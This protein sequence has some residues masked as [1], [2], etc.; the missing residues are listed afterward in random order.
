MDIENV[1]RKYRISDK[2]PELVEFGDIFIKIKR[3]GNG[4]FINSYSRNEKEPETNDFFQT[5]SSDSL[6]LIPALQTKP[7]VFKGSSLSIMPR[8]KLTFYVKI[9]M[10]V[11]VFHTNKHHDNLI[12]EIIHTRLSDTWFGEP[13]NGEAA[14]LLGSEYF[15]HIEELKIQQ[16]EAVCPVQV[17]NNSDKIL[18]LQ[19]LILR[20]E[21]MSLYKVNENVFT[22]F[23]KLEYK[24]KDVI[25]SANYGSSK[26]YHGEKLHILAKPGNDK[27]TPLKINFHFI[28]NIYKNA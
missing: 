17:Y 16:H 14:F 1:F 27:E 24:G 10:V 20:I 15:F 18:E 3:E 7:L 22:S 25:S 6:I 5:G 13:D 26:V 12:K 8:Q 23:V 11:Q 19:R 9:P 28:R 21:N 2:K 4:W